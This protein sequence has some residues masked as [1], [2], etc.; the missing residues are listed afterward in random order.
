MN[1]LEQVVTLGRTVVEVYNNGPV[2]NEEGDEVDLDTAIDFLNQALELL[3]S[4]RWGDHS[5]QEPI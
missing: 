2:L 1:Q 4:V 5:E 3:D